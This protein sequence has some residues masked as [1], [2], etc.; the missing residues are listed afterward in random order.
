[1]SEYFASHSTGDVG[2]ADADYVA[3]KGYPGTLAPGEK[4]LE[5]NPFDELPNRILHPWPAMQE[6]QFH[7]RMP[8]N[9]PMLPPMPLWF[10]LNNM[11]TDNVTN[12]HLSQ[13]STETVGGMNILPKDAIRIAR[14]HHIGNCF[15]PSEQVD[16]GGMIFKTGKQIP[17]YHP[18]H[19]PT[20]SDEE[21]KPPI[22]EELLP[23]TEMWLD[24]FYGIVGTKVSVPDATAAEQEEMDEE[25]ALR[26]AAAERLQSLM[27]GLLDR[28]AYQLEEDRLDTEDFERRRLKR[29]KRLSG[30]VDDEEV[31]VTD[32]AKP[33][34][35]DEPMLDRRAQRM[36]DKVIKG[37]ARD[38]RT[39]ITYSVD[40]IRALSVEITI[41]ARKEDATKK[42]FLLFFHWC[43]LLNVCFEGAGG[44]ARCRRKTS[45]PSP[46]TMSSPGTF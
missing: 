14:F 19:G 13:P 17:F 41:A 33:A 38:P 5:N 28:D 20:V 9:H 6:F 25:E 31:G 12:F 4:F 45:E 23:I 46:P 3:K 10:G 32:E 40:T 2:G 39:L 7:V 43:A 8:P 36:Q 16:H 21:A 22:P 29:L 35:H 1:M 27:P 11:Y 30:I 37:F 42:Y 15:E 26:I 24:P 18:D 44:E 34:G